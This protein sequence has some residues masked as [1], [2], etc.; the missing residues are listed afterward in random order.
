MNGGTDTLERR[1][2]VQVAYHGHCSPTFC[3]VAFSS[4]GTCPNPKTGDVSWERRG[5]APLPR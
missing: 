2:R 1:K 5:H 3:E 4:C